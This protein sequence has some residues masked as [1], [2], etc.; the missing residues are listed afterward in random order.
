MV[1]CI[2]YPDKAI[3]VLHNESSEA[4]PDTDTLHL[5]MR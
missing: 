2:H 4:G 3:S 1:R 5:I